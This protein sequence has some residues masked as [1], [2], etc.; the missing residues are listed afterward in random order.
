MTI[1]ASDIAMALGWVGAIG[2]MGAY[3]LV[4][5]GRF[6]PESLR[7]H[8]LNMAACALLSVACFATS[9]WPNLVVNV[10]FVVIGVRMTWRIRH[11]LVARVKVLLGSSARAAAAAH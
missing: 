8:A 5:T 4:S 9:A 2:S 10:L 7:Y 3:Y 11:R 6:H 1:S